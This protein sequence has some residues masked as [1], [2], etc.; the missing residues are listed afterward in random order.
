MKQTA[1]ERYLL[2]IEPRDA[3]E[4][5]LECLIYC[6]SDSEAWQIM[7]EYNGPDWRSH[8]KDI[9]RFIGRTIHSMALK[10]LTLKLS[11]GG[12]DEKRKTE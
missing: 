8:P 6:D 4:H 12:E 2:S 5:L 9:R 1:L 7:A 10:E 11:K 3:I